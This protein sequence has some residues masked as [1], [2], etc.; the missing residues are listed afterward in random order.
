MSANIIIFL[1]N[2]VL[3]TE[4][5]SSTILYLVSARRMAVILARTNVEWSTYS[6]SLPPTHLVSAP[7]NSWSKPSVLRGDPE[8]SYDVSQSNTI[9]WLLCSRIWFCRL[10]SLPIFSTYFSSSLRTNEKSWLVL[11]YLPRKYNDE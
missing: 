1:N 4:L 5:Y 3:F 7:A 10:H 11:V 9:S 8:G 2:K 6:P